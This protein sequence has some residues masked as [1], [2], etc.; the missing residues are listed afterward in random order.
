MLPLTVEKWGY[1]EIDTDEWLGDRAEFSPDLT[2]Q[3]T[4]W[5][6]AQG[7]SDHYV[8]EDDIY[9]W[10]ESLG[11]VTGLYGDPARCVVGSTYNEDNFLSSD[12]GFCF[13]HVESDEISETLII[14]HVTGYMLRYPGDVE[15][16]R[17]TGDDDGDAFGYASGYAAH[18]SGRDDCAGWIIES[19]CVLWP[20]GGG[21]SFRVSDCIGE[22][23]DGNGYLVC[24][25]CWETLTPY[26]D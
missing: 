23:D 18:T 25:L 17:F 14:V 22:D 3:F 6:E 20:N 12:F 2:D 21:E 15:V 5:A 1:L 26:A 11:T 24:P 7:L 13:A 19:A 4:D 9:R 8:R 10:L 16:Y